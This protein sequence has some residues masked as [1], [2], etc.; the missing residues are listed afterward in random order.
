MEKKSSLG[1]LF[2]KTLANHAL[3]VPLRKWG[4]GRR[5]YE[6]ASA[7]GIRAGLTGQSHF[8]R[9]RRAIGQIAPD[10]TGLSDYEMSKGLTHEA[11]HLIQKHTKGQVSHKDIVHMLGGK[12]DLPEH[13]KI[14]LDELKKNHLPEDSMLHKIK[15]VVVSGR[16]VLA[17]NLRGGIEKIKNEGVDTEGKG[18]FLRRLGRKYF[19]G[20]DKQMGSYI[21]SVA[22]LATG[23]VPTVTA[24]EGAL[25]G[26][27]NTGHNNPII[28]AKGGIVKSGINDVLSKNKEYKYTTNLT[29][30]DK[31][32]SLSSNVSTGVAQALSPASSEFKDF[33]RDIGRQELLNRRIVHRK[34]RLHVKIPELN[35]PGH[36]QGHIDN[37]K[38]NM[39]IHAKQAYGNIKEKLTGIKDRFNKRRLETNLNNTTSKHFNAHV[40]IPANKD[41]STPKVKN[42]TRIKELYNRVSSNIKD[43]L[44]RIKNRFLNKDVA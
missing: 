38:E 13:R 44:S 40:D 32:N 26:L 27:A 20:K 10:I 29:K 43:K 3:N 35:L 25:T 4:L 16:S 6:F 17:K 31:A 37:A 8:P 39:K 23:N 36:I 1:L 19:K 28:Y 12:T 9:L 11:S 42:R 5:A 22:E 30:L 21:P 2:G 18:G 14:L 24:A 34:A 15:G 41:I 33:G 7:S